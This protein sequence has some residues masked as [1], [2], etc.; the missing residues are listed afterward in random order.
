[1]VRF[2]LLLLHLILQTFFGLM[3]VFLK[4]LQLSL[5]L[6][7]HLRLILLLPL[8]LALQLSFQSCDFLFVSLRV[9][10]VL[11]L[12][13]LAL[14]TILLLT[15]PRLPQLVFLNLIFDCLEV[16]FCLL[17]FDTV[18][19]FTVLELLVELLLLDADL[20]QVGLHLV[21][22]MV[23]PKS[24]FSLLAITAVISCIVLIV[25]HGEVHFGTL[26]ILF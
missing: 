10:Q 9:F 24:R 6:L 17:E 8:P 4:I 25:E 19:G 14:D 20:L 3:L 2:D 15:L 13:L 22:T 23:C 11:H 12:R 21:I 16:S 26:G 18:S 1:M 7:F 5:V